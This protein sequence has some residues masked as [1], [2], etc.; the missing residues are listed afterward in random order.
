MAQCPEPSA[1]LARELGDVHARVAVPARRHAPAEPELGVRVLL[2]RVERGDGRGAAVQEARAGRACGAREAGLLGGALA[3]EDA[4]LVD[5]QDAGEED[6]GAGEG[7]RDGVRS[8]GRGHARLVHGEGLRL[9]LGGV[10][11]C[12]RFRRWRGGIAA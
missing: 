10:V 9:G 1:L 2:V 5:A 12:A 6:D 3:H 8:G 7:E 4:V 11:L